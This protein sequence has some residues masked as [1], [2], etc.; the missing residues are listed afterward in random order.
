MD[1]I[2]SISGKQKSYYINSVVTILIMICGRFIPPV[3]GITPFGME[4]LGIF[5]GAIYGWIAVGFIWPSF[6]AMILL[7][8]SDYGN[9]EAVFAE[10]FSNSVPLQ[11]MISF[12]FFEA[13]SKSGFIDYIANWMIS[14][15]INVGRP[16]VLSFILFL[17]SGLLSAVTNQFMVIVVFWFLIYS[18]CDQIGYSVKD[19][20]T[21][22]VLV[23]VTCFAE[24]TITLFPFCPFAIIAIGTAGQAVDLGTY[25]TIGWMVA[26]TAILI[27]TCLIYTLIGKYILRID[28]SKL[29]VGDSFAH[30][31]GKK[32]EGGALMGAVYLAVFILIIVLP[33]FLPDD[34]ALTIVLNK[35]GVLGACAVCFVGLFFKVDHDGN[36]KLNFAKFAKDGI[37]WEMLILVVATMPI[38]AAMESEDT[39]IVTAFVNFTLPLFQDMG[40][41]LFVIVSVGVLSIISQF[42]HNLILLFVFLPVLAK[43]ALELG[44]NP[45]LYVFLFMMGIDTAM[46]TPGG[47]AASAMMFGNTNWIERKK[48]Y[49]YAVI[50]VVLSLIVIFAVGY[51]LGIALF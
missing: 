24:L 36:S 14:L 26:G 33:T 7:G 22:Y 29:N 10:G 9:M 40:P 19:K 20:W 8:I 28:T 34:W 21:N 4:I 23:G 49:I 37:A 6:L 30:L 3:G 32:L 25:N 51:P 45:M 15:K 43:L 5:L 13:I 35:F 38:C 17:A 2:K 11:I 44:V 47:S 27:L 41:I 31:R 16:W 50:W 1:G 42:T 18:I 48:C 46:G 12:I 39:G